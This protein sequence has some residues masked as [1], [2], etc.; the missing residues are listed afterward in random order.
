MPKSVILMSPGLAVL[1]N[2]HQQITGL[3]I[4]M[5]DAAIV[6][7]PKTFAYVFGNPQNLSPVKA[8]PL[9]LHL[10]Q[11]VPLD[12]FHREETASRL[13]DRS[14]TNE[15]CCGWSSLSRA[16]I[17][18]SKRPRKWSSCAKVGAKDFD[19]MNLAGLFVDPTIDRPHPTPTEDPLEFV[20]TDFVKRHLELG[21]SCMPHFF[22]YAELLDFVQFN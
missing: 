21:L 4:P 6:S 8:V 22:V 9:S 17:S 13:P 20:W 3:E 19:G 10:K 11:A 16:L 12:Q 7:V 15:R 18:D 1:V 2:R 5:N 14:S